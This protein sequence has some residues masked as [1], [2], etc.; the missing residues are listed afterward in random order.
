MS[1]TGETPADADDFGGTF[2]SGSLTFAVNEYIKTV[3]FS[4][5]EDADIEGNETFK[6]ELSNPDFC[7]IDIGSVIGTITNDDA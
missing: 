5:S 2:P 4:S 3:S 6:V 7:T 1:G